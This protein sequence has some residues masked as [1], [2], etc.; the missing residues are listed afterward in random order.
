VKR[1]LD[2]TASA[3]GLL[4][5]SVVLLPAMALVW[6]QDRHSP[7]YVAPRVGRGG[8][9]FRMVKLRSMRILADTTGITSTSGD[10]PRITAVGRFIRRWKLDELMQLVNVLVGDMSLV[11]PRPQVAWAVA[12]YTAE[13]RELL[14]VRPG[15]TDLASIVFADEADILEGAADPDLR[16]EQVI[17]PWKSRLALLTVRGGRSLGS[18]LEIIRLTVLTILAR[19]RALAAASAL[20]LKLGGGEEL[21]RVAL[22]KGPLRE[23][24]PPG[25]R[26]VVRAVP[27]ASGRAKGAGA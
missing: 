2:L 1:L 22:R 12:A 19:P 11:G 6:L 16:Y 27:D 20:V 25:A 18:D 26:E 21:A 14:S 15:I 17:R 8:R 5:L 23:A 13:E 7:F 9:V 3:V 10:D 24:P 4:L